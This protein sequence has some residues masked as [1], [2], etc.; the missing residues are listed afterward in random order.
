[1]EFR[2][3]LHQKQ[4][5]EWSSG[6]GLPAGLRSSAIESGPLAAPGLPSSRV[7]HSEDPAWGGAHG[8]A[9][10]SISY[11]KLLSLGLLVRD[12]LRNGVLADTEPGMEFRQGLHQKQSQ[13]WSSGRGLPAGLRSSAIESGP[14]AAPGLPSSRV[15][16]SEDPAWGGAHGAAGKSISYMKLLSL[17]LLVRD[18][19]RNGV[20]AET[21]PGMEFWQGLPA[22]GV[23]F[24]IETGGLLGRLLGPSWGL[25]GPWAEGLRADGLMG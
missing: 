18:R 25:L 8:A 15:S 21:E 2:Q 1:M 11:M 16:H 17:G 13:E 4:S 20:L 24:A 7:S 12:R 14:L 19:L 6:R 3:G 23:S 9:G 5:Q 10:K 22:R